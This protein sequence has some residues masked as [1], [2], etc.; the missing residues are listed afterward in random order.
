MVSYQG[1]WTFSKDFHFKISALMKQNVP[2]MLW[3]Y[4]HCMTTS[5]LDVPFKL[6]HDPLTYYN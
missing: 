2:F 6:T 4:I 5:S 3:A 1:N